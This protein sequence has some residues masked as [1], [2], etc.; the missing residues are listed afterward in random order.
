MS[1]TMLEFNAGEFVQGRIFIVFGTF[2]VE[3]GL[4]FWAVPGVGGWQILANAVDFL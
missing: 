4:A 3:F 1:K 2:L